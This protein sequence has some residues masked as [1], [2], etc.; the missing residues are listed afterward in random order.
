[1]DNG[2]KEREIGTRN[3]V[4]SFVFLQLKDAFE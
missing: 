3:K 4:Q 2:Q 1:M